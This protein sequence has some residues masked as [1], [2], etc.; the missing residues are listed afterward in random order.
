MSFKLISFNWLQL[1]LRLPF[2]F[3]SSNLNTK[4]QIKLPAKSEADSKVERLSLASAGFLHVLL[5]DHKASHK[6]DLGALGVLN[7]VI[8]VR[9][10]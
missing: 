2:L 6:A 1:T 5:E 10:S 7:V 4:S 8:S 9:R 3:S